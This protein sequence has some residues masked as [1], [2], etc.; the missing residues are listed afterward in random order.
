MRSREQFLDEYARSHQNPLNQAIHLVCVPAIFWASLVLL[1]ALPLAPLLPHLPQAWATYFNGAVVLL[2]LAALFYLRL[3][4]TSL[5]IGVIW[6]LLSLGLSRLLL[7]ADLPLVAT[8]AVVWVLAWAVQF[9]GHHV[10]GAKPS[11]ADDLLF[12]L[13]GPLFVQQKINRLLGTGSL[14]PRSR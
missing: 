1:W 11:F 2:P 6:T 8:A 7:D 10:E 14:R 3:G 9:Y 5:V 4:V 12:L 13:V